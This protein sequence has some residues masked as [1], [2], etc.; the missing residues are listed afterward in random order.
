MSLYGN[1][2]CCCYCCC[3]CY[4]F[5]SVGGIAVDTTIDAVVVA[6]TLNAIDAVVCDII[7]VAVTVVN[8]YIAVVVS[9]GVTFIVVLGL[10]IEVACGFAVTVVIISSRKGLSLLLC[11]LLWFLSLL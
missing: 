10:A 4:L 2:Y 11:L 1:C 7:V 5:V 9:V 6:V 8:A 3:C